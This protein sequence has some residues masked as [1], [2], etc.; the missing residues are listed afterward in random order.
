MRRVNLALPEALAEFLFGHVHVD[1]LI[2]PPQHGVRDAFP[3]GDAGGLF[4]ARRHGFQMLHVDGRN[5]IDALRQHFEHIRVA[6]VVLGTVRV[7]V[8]QLVHQHDLR[9][10]GK[11]GLDVHFMENGVPHAPFAGGDGFQMLGERHRLGAVVGFEVPDHHIHVLLFQAQPLLQHGVGFPHAGR[12]SQIDFKGPLPFAFD[13]FRETVHDHPP[14]TE[15]T[16]F[17]A[18]LPEFVKSQ[19]EAQHI[20]LRFAPHAPFRAFHMAAHELFHRFRRQAAGFGHA[21]D[22]HQGRIRGNM[23]I[24]AA[25]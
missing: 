22:L 8:G 24:K 23:R 10:A 18:R 11:D 19:I 3:H 21:P 12:V 13:E 2:G 5:D 25:S 9:F 7:G 15:S 1:D 4:D 6:L 17:L 16:S 20:D 14:D